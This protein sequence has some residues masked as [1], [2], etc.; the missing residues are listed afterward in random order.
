MQSFTDIADSETI[1]NSRQ[2]LLDNDNTARSCHAGASFPTTNLQQGI[3]CLRT[4]QSKLYQLKSIGP[5]TWIC[6]ADLTKT[7]TTKEDSDTAY[8][9]KNVELTGVAA[10]AANGTIERTDVGTYAPYTVTAAAKSVLSQ[11]TL[12]LM[13]TALDCAKTAH[14]HVFADITD[15][16]TADLLP[17]TISA[18]DASRDLVVNSAGTAYVVGRLITISHSAPSGGNDGDIWLVY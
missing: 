6:I 12:P 8:Q 15:K 7:L 18:A 1:Q 17:A 13:R 4:D 3:L 9:P 14:T 11:G 5:D 16:K 2:K 10:L